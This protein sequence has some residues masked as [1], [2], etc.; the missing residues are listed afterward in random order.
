MSDGLDF[1][2]LKN[3][4]RAREST[5]KISTQIITCVKDKMRVIHNLIFLKVIRNSYVS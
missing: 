5:Q 3:Q 4:P 2:H 1:L